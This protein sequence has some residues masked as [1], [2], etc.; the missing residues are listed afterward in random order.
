M[1]RRKLY[2]SGTGLA[3]A[4]TRGTGDEPLEA[5]DNR[6]EMASESICPSL[7]A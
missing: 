3:F 5:S 4:F 1:W 2:Y 7:K 6:V